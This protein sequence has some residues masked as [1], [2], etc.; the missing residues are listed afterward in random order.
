MSMDNK[1]LEH[2]AWLCALEIKEEEKEKFSGQLNEIIQFVSK[3][4]KVDVEWITPLYHPIEESTMEL[5][6]WVEDKNFTQEFL[7]NTKHVIKD[8]W[9]VIRSSLK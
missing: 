7:D 6:N 9:I 5:N 8:N 4:Q 3:L 1:Q 2:L